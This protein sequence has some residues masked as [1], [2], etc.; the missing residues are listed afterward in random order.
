MKVRRATNNDIIS[1]EKIYTN[2]GWSESGFDKEFITNHPETTILVCENDKGEVV[3]TAQLNIIDS[4][5]HGCHPYAV[6]NYIITKQE[7]RRHGYMR[8]IFDEIDK[9]CME[10]K[11]IYVMLTSIYKP[12][13]E[14][15]TFLFYDSM[16]YVTDIQGFRKKYY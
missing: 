4:L 1:I 11:C 14:T 7:Y 8:A 6:L 10:H 13:R 16:G 12:E 15:S 5:A 2:E 9:I 3:A